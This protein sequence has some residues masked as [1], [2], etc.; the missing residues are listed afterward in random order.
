MII[1]EL[2]T[3][4]VVG[5]TVYD[6]GLRL[7]ELRKAKGL[8]QDEVAHKLNLTRSTISGY[9]HNIKNPKPDTIAKLAILYGTSADYILN[10]SDREYIYLDA[11]SESQ[12]KLITDFVEK[13]KSEFSL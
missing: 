7:R 10:L 12:K 6:F 11:F 1:L 3:G 2:I 9:E 13:L 8:S 4:G 5:L